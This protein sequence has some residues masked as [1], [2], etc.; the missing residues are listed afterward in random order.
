M[1][2]LDGMINNLNKQDLSIIN[3]IFIYFY[4]KKR[5]NVLYYY[6]LLR[7]VVRKRLTKGE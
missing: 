5:I 6:C 7:E 1:E 2:V 3:K 4:N